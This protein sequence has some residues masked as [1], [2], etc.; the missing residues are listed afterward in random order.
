ML[1]LVDFQAHACGLLITLPNVFILCC[2]YGNQTILHVGKS[3]K[4][5]KARQFVLKNNFRRCKWNSPF[6]ISICNTD[7]SLSSRTA[8]T[9]YRNLSCFCVRHWPNSS[10]RTQIWTYFALSLT[11]TQQTKN[12]M[13][14]VLC[15]PQTKHTHFICYGC[16]SEDSAFYYLLS[17]LAFHI[18]FTLTDTSLFIHLIVKLRDV[19]VAMAIFEDQVMVQVFTV[20]SMIYFFS[21]HT[22]FQN[23]TWSQNQIHFCTRLHKTLHST[24]QNT[25]HSHKKT[26]LLQ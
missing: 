22:H 13:C 10:S 24:Q 2:F 5:F 15:Q 23:W 25:I 26:Q 16:F 18:F 4:Q 6:L 1:L 3:T 20:Q 11:C 17:H 12:L 21:P 19:I 8:D 7:C 9:L 14:C